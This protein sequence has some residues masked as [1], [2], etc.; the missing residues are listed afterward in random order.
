MA[1]QQVEIF[2]TETTVVFRQKEVVYKA[3]VSKDIFY[4]ANGNYT[5][6]NRNPKAQGL[7]KW[8]G[9]LKKSIWRVALILLKVLF[10]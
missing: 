3:E 5:G 2:E 6:A 4:P 8:L 10:S 7:K 9:Y 1:R